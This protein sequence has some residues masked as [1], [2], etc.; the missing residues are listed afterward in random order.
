[1]PPPPGSP[2]TAADDATDHEI[3]GLTNDTAYTVRA[4]AANDAGDGPWSA[5]ASETPIA[6]DTTAPSVDSA[7]VSQDGTSIDIV[8]DEDLDR[9]GTASAAS[10]FEVTVDGGTAVNPASVAFKT[11]DADTITL[12]MATADAIGAGET[13]S[14]D[15]TKPTA[16]PLKDSA[17]NEV[18]AFTGRA[19]S[20]RLDAPA[21]VRAYAGNGRVD[22]EWD[23]PHRERRHRATRCNG[24][25][26]PTPHTTTPAPRR[27]SRASPSTGSPV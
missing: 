12:T 21:E 2:T 27:W 11:G 16:N 17:D 4:R 5:E 10:A 3:T 26:P 7:T 22:V 14:V 25:L 15:Y 9:S 20:N 8:F 1:M 19:V 13:V 23:A 18:A 6:G 24:R